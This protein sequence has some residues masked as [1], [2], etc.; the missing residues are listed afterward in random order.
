MSAAD[1]RSASFR[2]LF[3]ATAAFNQ[4]AGIGRY[5]RNLIPAALRYLSGVD[6]TIWH[7]PDAGGASPF[8]TQA[9]T[10]LA[11]LDFD[12][13]RTPIHRLRLDQLWFRAN[14]RLPIQL[15]AGNQDLIYSPDFTAPPGFRTP[16]I[17]TVHDLAFLTHP[18]RTSRALHRYL[19]RVVPNQIARA[20]SIVAV[21]EATR[22]ELL[23]RFAIDPASV[24]IVPNG[25][26]ERFFKA[27][28]LSAEERKKLDLPGEYLLSVGTIEPR[29]NHLQL[30]AALETL[31]DKAVPPLVV[32]G[33]KGWEYEPILRAAQPLITRG[34]VIL[35]DYVPEDLLPGLYAGASAVLYPSWSEGFGL[36]VLEALAAGRPVVASRIPAHL[37]VAGDTATLIDPASTDGLAEGI[38]RALKHPL[39]PGPGIRRAKQYAWSRSGRALATLFVEASGGRLRLNKDGT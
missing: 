9:Q 6:A 21:S 35:L 29:K 16:S 3:D 20:R 31:G 18:E 24:S 38:M 33:R 25:V 23:E 19:A 22:S 1:G 10:L 7:A 13:K 17:V 11:G 2:V 4:G 26:E 12:E 36:P 34:R 30:F 39:D 15:L 37:E 5:A 14:L 28:S 8:A 27:H 32:A